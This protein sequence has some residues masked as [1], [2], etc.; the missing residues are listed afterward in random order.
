MASHRQLP[1]VFRRLHP[2]FKTPWLSLLVFAGLVA[3]A[4]LLPGKTTFLG[5]MYA[6]GAMLSFTIAHAAVVALRITRREREMRFRARP[7]ISVAGVSWPLFAIFGGLG[8]AAAW[9][10]VVVQKPAARWVG[11]GW[12]IFGLIFYAVYRRYV[13][14]APLRETLRAPILIGPAV[15]LEYRSILVPVK[16]GRASEEAIDF[17]C[18]LAA[19]RGSAIAA[20]SVVV[21]PL[22]LPLDAEL[23][24]EEAEADEALDAAVAI[25]ELYGVDVTARLLRA[26]SPGRAIVREAERRQTEIIVLGAPRGDR[27]RRAIFSET[28][29]YILK[30]APCR[31]MVVAGQKAAA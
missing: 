11:V 20:V 31:V 25:G 2:R 19:Q 22:E 8:T 9:I 5:D 23:P 29:D 18:R 12:L 26:R 13:V 14:R 15:A 24:E 10:V 17:S 4:V 6:F 21:V 16:P 7:N 27:V 1:E 3:I 28:V 30:N